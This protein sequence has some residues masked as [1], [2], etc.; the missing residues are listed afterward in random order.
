MGL[1]VPK[2][3]SVTFAQLVEEAIKRIPQ[4]AP[5]WT[6]HN[7]HDPGITLIELFAWFAEMQSF[8]LDQVTENHYRKFLELLGIEL[9][10][11]EKLKD[12]ILRAQK[13]LK[14][15][16]RAVTY[17]DFEYLAKET[18][19]A[20]IART[21]AVWNKDNNTVE[22]IVVPEERTNETEELRNRVCLYLDKHRLLT[23]LIEVID[24]EYVLVSVQAVIRTKPL[25]SPTEVKKRVNDMLEIFFDPRRGYDGSGWPFGRTVYAS[26]VCTR[27]EDVEGVDCVQTLVL[28]AK[29]KATSG[30]LDI[31]RNALTDSGVHE[32]KIVDSQEPCRKRAIV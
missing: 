27:I 19:D 21:K 32:I 17:D 8:Y 4:Y 7:L 13:D 30:D 22:I 16:Y 12:A 2:L 9:E 26:E 24:P 20:K 14:K 18:P 11:D 31:G 25:A 1:K 15:P 6:D 23:T 5:D 3:D 28:S 10:P 29:G